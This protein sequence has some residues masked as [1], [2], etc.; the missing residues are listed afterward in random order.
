[1]ARIGFAKPDRRIYEHVLATLAIAPDECV[2][3]D[4]SPPKCEGARAV[5]MHVVDYTNAADLERAL[6]LFEVVA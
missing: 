6:R 3:T 5:G 1:M 4:D 2:F